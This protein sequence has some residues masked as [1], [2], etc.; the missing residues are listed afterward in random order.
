MLV[1]MLGRR[2]DRRLGKR[3]GRGGRY[4]RI[5]WQIQSILVDR[6]TEMLFWIDVL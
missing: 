3:L 6:M 5:W 1:R 4:R 2:L